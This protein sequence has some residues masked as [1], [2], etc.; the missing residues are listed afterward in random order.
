M[1]FGISAVIAP[2]RITQIERAWVS[3]CANRRAADA[4]NHRA[5]ARIP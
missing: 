2:P 5:G 4:A 1:E 3:Q